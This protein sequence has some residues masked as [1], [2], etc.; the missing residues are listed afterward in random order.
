MSDALQE[1]IDTLSELKRLHQLNFELLEQL[2]IVCQWIIDAHLC[3]PNEEKMRS[4]LGKSLILLNEI[5][6]DEPKTIQYTTDSRR[7]V[8]AFKTDEDVPVP[9][10]VLE[11][12]CRNL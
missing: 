9:W 7:K 6:A 3:I 4:L 11:M 8:T 5:Q 1:V 12:E 2:N 10:S